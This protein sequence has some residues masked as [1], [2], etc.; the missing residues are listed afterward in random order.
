MARRTVAAFA[1]T[2]ALGPLASLA[3]RTLSLY[4]PSYAFV[5][6]LVWLLWPTWALAVLEVSL[7][8]PVAVSSAIG[9]NLVVFG[10]TGVLVA[11]LGKWPILQTLVW[12]GCLGA[13]CA[14]A[15]LGSGHAV[16]YVRWLPLLVAAILVSV[17]FGVAWW[18]HNVEHAE[19]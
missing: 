14:W 8:T 1:A 3:L 7:G 15:W 17:P 4:S 16:E 19:R 13:L 12:T 18:P 10:M 6:Q 11:G 9:A 5:H 2:G